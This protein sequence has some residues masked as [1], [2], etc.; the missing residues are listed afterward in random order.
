MFFT[1]RL[2]LCVRK[3]KTLA[4]D[5]QI[6]ADYFEKKKIFFRISVFPSGSYGFSSRSYGFLSGYRQ[7]ISPVSPGCTTKFP[8]IAYCILYQ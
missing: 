1:Q 4:A 3:N 5:S 8:F 7:N 6:C 2:S